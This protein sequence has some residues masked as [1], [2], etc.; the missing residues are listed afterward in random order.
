MIYINSLMNNKFEDVIKRELYSKTT[1]RLE[2][3]RQ[4]ISQSI[5]EMH[6]DLPSYA[7]VHSDEDP[8]GASAN[9]Y[10][11]CMQS[12]SA[13]HPEASDEE[14]LKLVE[15]CM[16]LKEQHNIPP[17]VVK[18]RIAGGMNTK[19]AVKKKLGFKGKKPGKG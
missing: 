12:V 17:V 9:K 16:Q 6:N 13:K 3:I 4:K 15:V 2:E 10:N 19:E 8:A 14:I 5:L 18:R 11:M 1:E 7:A